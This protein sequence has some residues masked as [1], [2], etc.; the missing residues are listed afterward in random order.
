MTI[1]TKFEINQQVLWLHQG[2]VMFGKVW[3]ANAFTNEKGSN[4]VYR[5]L[6]SPEPGAAE[7]IKEVFHDVQENAIYQDDLDLIV[8][9]KK[10]LG[11]SDQVI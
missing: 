1:V 3:G 5:L 4:V 9:I 10:Q 11:H 8:D 2:R 7:E 6:Q